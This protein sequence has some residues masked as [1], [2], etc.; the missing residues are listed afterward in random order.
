MIR[1]E[2]S[3]LGKMF[4]Q[5]GLLHMIAAV[6]KWNAVHGA[7][8]SVIIVIGLWCANPRIVCC[9]WKV[10]GTWCALWNA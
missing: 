4:S 10:V 2:Q 7:E 6:K 3:D 9:S 5:I 8:R 1:T